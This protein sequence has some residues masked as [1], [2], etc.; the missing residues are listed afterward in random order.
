MCTIIGM[1]QRSAASFARLHRLEAVGP[2][3]DAPIRTL[4]PVEDV[5]IAVG[6]EL[7]QPDVAIVDVAQ[8]EVL[9]DQ[10]DVG[11]IEEGRDTRTCDFSMMNSRN[12]SSDSAPGEPASIQL[13]TPVRE[14]SASASTPQ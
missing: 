8:L 5:A 4:T 2:D 11:D 6:D 10:A 7:E 1:P 14:P 9:A 3:R 13:V 12:P